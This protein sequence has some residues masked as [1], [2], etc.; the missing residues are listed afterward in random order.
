[1]THTELVMKYPP[2][3]G[4]SCNIC[5]GFCRRPGWWSIEQARGA[6]QKGYSRRMMMEISPEFTFA[7]L[8][9]AFKGNEGGIAQKTKAYSLCT[10]LQ[11]G[12]CELHNTDLFPLECAFCHHD[13][14]GLGQ[15]C[16]NDLELNWNTR[17]GQAMVLRWCE[18]NNYS[19]G[20][21]VA[22]WFYEKQNR[23]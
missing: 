8:S 15:K 4:C 22:R 14:I 5:C 23:R 13:R 18:K 6:M 16:H 2:S 11:N 20:I 21:V 7:V 19:E 9:P 3:E 10:F 1:M 17:R 12:R